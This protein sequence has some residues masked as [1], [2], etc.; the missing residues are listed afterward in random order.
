MRVIEMARAVISGGRRVVSGLELFRKQTSSVRVLRATLMPV[1]Q[2]MQSAARER[3]PVRTGEL[4]DSLGVEPIKSR[5]GLV[6]RAGA[7]HAHLI[8][9]GTKH[10]GARPFMRSALA[11]VGPTAG[12]VFAGRYRGTV[13]NAAKAAGLWPR[14]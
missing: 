1:A 11:S 9:F 3:V 6:V 8:E 14:R 12:L 5:P 7:R 10:H 4:R 13:A 2:D